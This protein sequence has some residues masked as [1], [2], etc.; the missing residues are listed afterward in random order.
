MIIRLREIEVYSRTASF[1]D[2][3]NGW[4]YGMHYSFMKSHVTA[5]PRLND[6]DVVMSLIE[7]LPVEVSQ[8]KNSQILLLRFGK[9]ATYLSH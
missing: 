7:R 4:V 3:A 1:V 8:A 5:V 9:V 2:T 6:F